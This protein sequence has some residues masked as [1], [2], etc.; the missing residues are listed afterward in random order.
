MALTPTLRASILFGDGATQRWQ[1]STGLTQQFPNADF[2]KPTVT[3]NAQPLMIHTTI[4]LFLAKQTYLTG[5]AYTAIAGNTGGYQIGLIGI[6][7]VLP[8]SDRFAVSL[9]AHLGAGG[10]AGVDTQ[11]GLLAGA[12]IALDY[13]LSDRLILSAAIGQVR[14]LSGDGMQPL[15]LSAGVKIPLRTFH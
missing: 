13:Q 6:G 2:Y 8:L 14:T 3:H 4:D 9:E 10:G 11:G 12:E 1:V 5:H 15:T 7:Y